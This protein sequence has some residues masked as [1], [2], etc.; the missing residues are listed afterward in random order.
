MRKRGL[1]G[2]CRGGAVITAPISGPPQLLLELPSSPPPATDAAPVNATGDLPVTQLI[3][4][5]GRC[6]GDRGARGCQWRQVRCRVDL[7]PG[8]KMSLAFALLNCPSRLTQAEAR[9]A[10]AELTTD[11]QVK[12]AEPDYLAQPM[13]DVAPASATSPNDTYYNPPNASCGV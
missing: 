2:N 13:M 7:E 8:R 11:P 6:R 1:R 12:Y 5:Y 4:K 3:V 9:S 10:A